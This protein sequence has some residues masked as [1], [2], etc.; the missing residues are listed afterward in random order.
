MD[1]LR[2]PKRRV[3]AEVHLAGGPP[4]RVTLFLAEAAVHHAGPE[5]PGDLL[6]GTDEFVPA[7]DEAAQAMSFL[8]RGAVSVVRLARALDPG[9]AEALT[10]PTEHE[11]QVHL[12]D[13]TLLAGLVSFL[14]PPDSARL[15]DFLNEASPFFRLLEADA[16]ALVNKR[17][18]ARVTLVSR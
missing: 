12:T 15:V 18:V 16:V 5:S 2:V 11:V 17:H 10:L 13:G 6:N 3:A 14:R 1:E 9:D 4:R 8:H 7:Y